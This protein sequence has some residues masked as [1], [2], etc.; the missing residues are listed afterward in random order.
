MLRW[1]AA[2]VAA[3]VV[4][5][6]LWV[7]W[8]TSAARDV[9]AI[10][11]SPPD[12]EIVRDRQGVPHIRGATDPD[13]AYGLA[14]AHAED[15]FLTIQQSLLAAR[16]DLA[17]V[18]GRDAAPNDYMV[19]L[20]RVWDTVGREYGRQLSADTRALVEAYADGLNHYAQEHPGDAL[21]GLFPVDG[22][23]VVA[24]SVHKSPLFFGLEETL[25]ALFSDE[26]LDLDHDIGRG[27][28][29]GPD[30]A[31]LGMR[32]GSNVFAVD[33]SLTA[34][35]STQLVVNSHQ[36]WTG[37]VAWYEA[38]V[39][40]DDGWHAAGALFPGVPTIVLGHNEQLAWSFT[41]NHPDLVDV[42]RLDGDPDDPYRYRVDGRW[43]RFEVRTVPIEV[44][45]AGR[46]RWTF[47]REALW[48]IFGPVVRRPDGLYAVRYAGMGTA[49]IYEQLYRMNRAVSRDALLASFLPQQG[50][51][52]FNL[53][54][55]DARGNIGYVYNALLP[56]RPA[57]P[58]WAGIVR[59]DTRATLWDSYVPFRRLPHVGNPEAGWIQN[60]NSTPYSATADPDAPDPATFAATGGIERY[61]TNRSL[62]LRRLLGDADAL[63]EDDVLAIK[64][65]LVWDTASDIAR[66]ADLIG[67][68]D[69]ATT[70]RLLDAAAIVR[71]W[72]RTAG[73]DDPATTLMVATLSFLD[74]DLLEPSRLVDSGIPDRVVLD[75]FAAAVDWLYEHHGTVAVPWGEVNRLIRG[76][77]DL[78]LA[79]APDLMH[80]IYPQRR[81]DGTFEAIAGDSFVMHVRFSA[82][83]D[84]YSSSV[85]QF[86][87]ATLDPASRH[88]ADQAPLFARRELTPVAFTERQV[89]SSA[90]E[91]Y[92]P[93][94]RDRG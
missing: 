70:D 90:A 19:G 78:P 88:H 75:A 91:R 37:P 62:R 82:A 36:P 64:Y 66:W 10:E 48:S 34:D 67:R 69:A 73:L 5:A 80:A 23:D 46:L 58:D 79:G 83:G 18:Y 51:P 59:G 21:P 81:D 38:S 9:A 15:D 3:V 24:T 53:G 44:K 54:Y 50:L 28:D 86:G 22:R 33:P 26:P 60:A 6:A 56:A 89:D 16:G 27:V 32:H 39:R 63:T 29:P 41:V 1:T 76:D 68:I 30:P 71:D 55:A 35:G 13:V 42:Y 61:E 45:L 8:P 40:S 25:A 47:E 65:D 87:S 52:T 17:T 77:V 74:P 4:A 85:H 92:R 84:V 20:L 93:G 94:E 43:Y 57:G 11:V 72:D 14:Y 49:G 2:V 12:V 7:A 31:G